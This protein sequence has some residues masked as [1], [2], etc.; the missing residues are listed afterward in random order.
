MVRGA[1]RQDPTQ[2][3]LQVGADGEQELCHACTS[4]C[5]SVGFQ[6][7]HLLQQ[8]WLWCRPCFTVI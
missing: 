7:H 5:P 3:F 6:S 1:Q 4:P 2:G 8:G